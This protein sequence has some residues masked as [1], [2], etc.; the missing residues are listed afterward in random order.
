MLVNESVEGEA[1]TPAGG[2][3]TNIDVGVAGGLHLTPEQQC[4][5]RL[6]DLT[7]VH[8]LHCYVLNLYQHA[9]TRTRN[10]QPI[11]QSINQ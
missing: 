2:E 3:V 5:L 11:N 4:V 6:L 1:V 8:L 10:D 7:A 9:H